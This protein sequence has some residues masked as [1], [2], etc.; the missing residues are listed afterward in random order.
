MSSHA[1]DFTRRDL[2]PELSNPPKRK[3][4]GDAALIARLKLIISKI[5]SDDYNEE[6]KM[7]IYDYN[8]FY[9]NPEND[10]KDVDSETLEGVSYF[11]AGWWLYNSM[12]GEPEKMD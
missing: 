10:E 4:V 1:T 6:M 12:K 2:V 5:E 3:Y 8:E 11:V 7:S 9:V